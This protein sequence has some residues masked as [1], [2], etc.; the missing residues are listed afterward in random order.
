MINSLEDLNMKIAY[1][2]MEDAFI[3]LREALEKLEKSYR[4]L[5]EALGNVTEG[6]S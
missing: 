1:D 5:R 2:A 3:E 6:S 4:K